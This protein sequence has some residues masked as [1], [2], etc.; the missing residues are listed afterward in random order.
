ML[1]ISIYYPMLLLIYC[2][3]VYLFSSLI[4]FA[5]SFCNL[6]LHSSLQR[7]IERTKSALSV[8]AP[9][10]IFCPIYLALS[11][12]YFSVLLPLK[13]TEYI[14][15]SILSNKVSG[16]RLL[17]LLVLSGTYL[18]EQLESFI[19]EF[20]LWGKSLISFPFFE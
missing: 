5:M 1:N 8:Y 6:D 3:S 7:L 4:Y 19:Q 11:C 16:F 12:K 2:C 15:D 18:L 20:L 17:K 14:N 9:N 10:L 13:M